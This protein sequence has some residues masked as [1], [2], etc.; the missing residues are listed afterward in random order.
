MAHTQSL[1]S[2]KHLDK[3]LS[4]SYLIERSACVPPDVNLGE[5]VTHM[6]LSSTNKA[7][8]SNFE[9]HRRHHQKFK[10]GI[11]QWPHE[12]DI[13]PPNFFKQ[14]C[15]PVGCILPATVAI[16]PATDTHLHHTCL[17]S[18]C[19]PPL[20]HACPPSPRMPPL[21]HTPPSPCMT[22]LCHAHPPCEQN[23]RR[24]WKYYLAPNFVCGR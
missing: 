13:C 18:P 10:T 12:K 3:T 2:W 9:T 20:Y 15:I 23:N 11:Y 16:C 8:D 19:M 5:H 6:P 21:P 17:P 1:L 7:A 22:P 4:S 24:L 14:E